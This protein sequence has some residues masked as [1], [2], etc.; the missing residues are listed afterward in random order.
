MKPMQYT[1][2]PVTREDVRRSMYFRM[3]GEGLLPYFMYGFDS[4][5]LDDW[6]EQT[7]TD[8]DRVFGACVDIFG[9]YQ[10]VAIFTRNAYRIWSF[11]FTSFREAFDNAPAV[12][13]AGFQWFFERQGEECQT[14]MGITPLLHRHALAVAKA[15]GFVRVETVLPKACW[16]ARRGRCVDGALVL[17][18][19]ETL[20]SAMASNDNE[21][22]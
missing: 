20:A 16:Y 6:L 14:I 18:T 21:K 17:C 19:R 7:T 13:R 2:Y 10:G 8:N 9:A 4:V 22:E 3:K 15:C 12:A 1:C 11:D 5:S